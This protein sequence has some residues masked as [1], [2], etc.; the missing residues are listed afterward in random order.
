MTKDPALRK[1]Y[2]IPAKHTFEEVGDG[3]VRVTA[4]DGRSGLFHWTGRWI[5]GDLTQCNLHML[6]W[7]GSPPTPPE[8]NFRWVESPPHM[9]TPE[10]PWPWPEK[11]QA[12]EQRPPPAPRDR[13]S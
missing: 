10:H 9:G 3:T 6:S 5:E 2:H 4:A 7:C 8:M 12:K 11:R 13:S 1:Y